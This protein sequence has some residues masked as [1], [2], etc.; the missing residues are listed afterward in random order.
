MAQVAVVSLQS[1]AR[2]TLTTGT[3]ARYLP[4]G[5][6]L[7]AR[8]NSLWRAPLDADAFALRGP[9]APVLEPLAV[10]AGG[11]AALYTVARNGSLVYAVGGGLGGGSLVW[12]DREGGAEPLAM[13]PGIYSRPRVS[14]DGTRVA[15]QL[16]AG[17]NGDIWIH[18]LARGTETRLTTDPAD[19]SNPLWG[20]GG[21][22]VVFT[23][24]RSGAAGLYWKRADG[25]GNAELLTE[26]DAATLFLSPTAWSADGDTLVFTGGG[27]TATGND[28][29]LLSMDTERSPTPLLAT[30][31]SE[32]TPLVS[33][34]GRWMAYVSDESGQSEIYVQRFPELGEKVTISTDGGAQPVWSPD[35][36][37][38][39]YR[40]PGAMMVVPVTTG[41]TFRAGTA[42][43]LFVDRYFG[44]S[45]GISNYDVAPDGRFLMLATNAD[46]IEDTAEGQLRVVLNWFEELERASAP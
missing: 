41:E 19:D 20:P 33:P 4:T 14:P 45:G 3:Q 2:T 9:A 42:E 38:L 6:I 13:D 37:E 27:I 5:H 24:D 30:E 21:D 17:A 16:E 29:Y 1:G 10:N 44:N 46:P 15:V 12:V 25:S 31:F 34:D 8:E 39:Y 32:G 40:G 23:S 36:T 11:G 26:G 18:D 28:V 43:T 22:R 7:F 35:G